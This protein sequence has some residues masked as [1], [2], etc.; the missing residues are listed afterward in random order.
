MWSIPSGTCLELLTAPRVF[1][2]LTPNAAVRMMGVENVIIQNVKFTS[3]NEKYVWGG[4]GLDI[5]KSDLPGL[6]YTR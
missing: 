2:L 1:R 5:C 3:I 4:D 6:Q